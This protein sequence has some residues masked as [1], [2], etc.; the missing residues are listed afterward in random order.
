MRKVLIT[1]PDYLP[2]LG[3][4]TTYTLQLQSMLQNIAGIECDVFHWQNLNK[5]KKLKS[6]AAEYEY[7]FHVNYTAGYISG[8]QKA[9]QINIVHGSE[10]LFYSPNIL[11]RIYKRL[12]RRNIIKYFESS[13]YNVFISSFTAEVLKGFGFQY[14][15]SRDFILHNVTN[16]SESSFVENPIDDE[17]VLCTVARDVEHKNLQGSVDLAEYMAKHLNKK[18]TLY[19]S[20]TKYKSSIVNL[21]DIS[22]IS[23]QEREIIYRKSHFNLLLSKD[24]SRLGFFE[25]FGL[26][27]LEAGKYGTPSIVSHTG[28]LPEN[29]HH[30]KN[31][32]VLNLDAP[33]ESKILED[34]NQV[35]RSYNE[36]R[37]WTYDHTVNSHGEDVC[38]KFL[39]RILLCK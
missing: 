6:I 4:L 28:G 21:V 15:Y 3:G 39:E 34:I 27:C 17:I 19:L 13:H 35:L 7:I 24:N 10:I 2:K 16:I 20:S 36:V 31:G 32:V 5:V 38:I 29:V 8:V 11:K 9:K 30:L 1:T 37:R 25:G 12:F 14:D 33:D 26:T 22:G 23:D 18:V